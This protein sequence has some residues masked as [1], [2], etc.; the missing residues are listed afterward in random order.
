MGNYPLECVW[1]FSEMNVVF[2]HCT[3]RIGGVRGALP[4][5]SC[6]GCKNPFINK[7]KTNKIVES[8][9]ATHCASSSANGALFWHEKIIKAISKEISDYVEQIKDD[10]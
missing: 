10:I 4:P 7:E 5:L 1:L 2:A 9:I 8:S 3:Y 6:S